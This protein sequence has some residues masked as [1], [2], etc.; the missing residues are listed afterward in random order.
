VQSVGT[1]VSAIESLR[2]KLFYKQLPSLY[3]EHAA[4]TIFCDN[5]I[6]VVVTAQKDILPRIGRIV[7][8]NAADTGEHIELYDEEGNPML[9]IPSDIVVLYQGAGEHASTVKNLIEVSEEK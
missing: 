1:T 3:Q 8:N 7:L 4:R 5:L 6:W 9:P 2:S